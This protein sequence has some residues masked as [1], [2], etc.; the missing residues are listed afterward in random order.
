ME[1]AAVAVKAR[2]RKG[3]HGLVLGA[4]IAGLLAARVLSDYFERVTVVERDV[5]PDGP[6][7]RRGVPQDRHPHL[8]QAGGAQALHNLFPGILAELET[9]GS[10]V[11]VEDYSTFHFDVGGHIVAKSGLPNK[12]VTFYLQTRPFLESC[13]RRR[14]REL[15]NV[16]IL[17]G[18]T[19]TDLVAT[20]S[21]DVT[22]ATV[23][24]PG[25]DEEVVSADLVVDAMGRGGRTPAFLRRHG[26]DQPAEDRVVARVTYSAQLV[27][28]P[29]DTLPAAFVAVDATPERPIGMLLIPQENSTAMFWLGGMVGHQP[30]GQFEAMIECAEPFSPPD[31]IAALRTVTPIGPTSQHKIPAAVWRRYD[32]M[33]TF[34]KG[35]LVIGDAICV[36]NPTYGQG[37]SVAA[38]QALALQRSLAKRDTNVARQFFKAAAKPTAAAWGLAAAADL[39][40]PQAQGNR[41]LQVRLSH[42]LEEPVLTAA[43]TDI[44][45]YS[46]VLKVGAFVDP[47]SSLLAPGFLLRLLRGALRARTNSPHTAHRDGIERSHVGIDSSPSQ[48]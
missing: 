34:P 19:V 33:R 47:P 22:G 6:E 35:L 4:S 40:Y 28:W 10:A 16:T 43:E 12:P 17:D 45:V 13:V 8:L 24:S 15:A 30:P 1:V 38:L 14:V 5:L 11:V 7:H 20:D 41:N 3:E 31:V 36:F 21:G 48:R 18:H 9:A 26:F 39:A 25:D 27:R 44:E 2:V 29:I 46:Q 37:M 23:T 42:R 32:Q